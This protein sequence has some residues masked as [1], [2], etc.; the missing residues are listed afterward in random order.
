M[1]GVAFHGGDFLG[2]DAPGFDNSSG[3]KNRVPTLQRK[4]TNRNR[5][6]YKCKNERQ[7]DQRKA[8]QKNVKD[9]SWAVSLHRFG[10]SG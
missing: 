8:D 10:S 5:R 9:G 4:P 6:V 2:E 1:P 3:F 7:N